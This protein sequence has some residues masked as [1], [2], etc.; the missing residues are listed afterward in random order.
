M[1]F[2]VYTYT[3]RIHAYK[4]TLYISMCFGWISG[5]KEVVI[6]S[7]IDRVEKLLNADYVTMN[8]PLFSLMFSI[9]S[10]EQ[11]PCLLLLLL[12]DI[13][14]DMNHWIYIGRS[15]CCFPLLEGGENIWFG[16][17]KQPS[18]SK[19]QHGGGN[20]PRHIN[21]YS[22][23]ASSAPPSGARFIPP[24]LSPPPLLPLHP[25]LP[26]YSPSS[27]PSPL[28]PTLT[29]PPPPSRPRFSIC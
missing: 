17:P 14:V 20:D 2:C 4:F 7:A 6:I 23:T 29:P 24:L 11:V 19:N 5:S 26:P 10:P 21:I 12:V 13:Y 25:S 8:N 15:D 1:Y 18:A 28:S 22:R 3:M 9:V 27:S 16:A